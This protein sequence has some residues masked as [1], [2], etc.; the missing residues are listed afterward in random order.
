[1]LAVAPVILA[2]GP[3]AAVALC[4]CEPRPVPIDKPV[5][6]KFTTPPAHPVPAEITAR[7]PLGVPEQ[8][9]LGNIV[10]Q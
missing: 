3:V 2:Q 9:G 10:T 4:H 5:A 6:D 8:P 7:P 1:M